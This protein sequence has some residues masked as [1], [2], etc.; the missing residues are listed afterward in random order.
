MA[1]AMGTRRKRE[2]FAA[3]QGAA[4][5]RVR[6]NQLS[7]LMSPLAGLENVPFHRP[8]PTA[9]A[10]GYKRSPARRATGLENVLSD[11]PFPTAVAVGYKIAPALRAFDRRWL[12]S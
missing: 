5:G 4:S 12:L 2:D 11:V 10:V 8:F 9:R 1:Q 6:A 7:A 3:P